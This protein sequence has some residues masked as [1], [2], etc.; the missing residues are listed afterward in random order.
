MVFSNFSDISEFVN[1]ALAFF[2][3]YKIRGFSKTMLI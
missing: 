3:A 2:D 1:I